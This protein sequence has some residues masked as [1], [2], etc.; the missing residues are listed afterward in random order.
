MRWS[1]WQSSG[2]PWRPD[3]ESRQN[4]RA[5][6]H[7][8]VESCDRLRDEKQIVSLYLKWYF[9]PSL[10]AHCTL[11]ILHIYIVHTA[12]FVHEHSLRFLLFFHLV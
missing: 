12:S 3:L 5:H 1:S 7:L 8:L 11:F 6:V 10:L 9:L 2:Q 4:E